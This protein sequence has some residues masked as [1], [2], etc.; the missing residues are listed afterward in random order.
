MPSFNACSR[1]LSDWV[2]L[3]REERTNRVWFEHGRKV[4][5]E[6]LKTF[7]SAVQEVDRRPYASVQRVRSA[8]RSRI[9]KPP[10][11]QAQRGNYRKTYCDWLSFRRQ[12]Q[13]KANLY[14]L[15]ML[16]KHR[17]KD[18]HPQSSHPRT[19]VQLLQH[20]HCPSHVEVPQKIGHE[21]AKR[22]IS[23]TLSIYS[24]RLLFDLRGKDRLE[25]KR[26]HL[27]LN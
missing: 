17:G 12:D 27:R 10:S 4:P 26:L 19:L 8:R 9:S 1:K 14:L 3:Q 22:G 2:P 6:K 20:Y 18:V 7:S 15:Q 23:G 21:T 5:H 11:R 25:D 13:I 24:V 16:E